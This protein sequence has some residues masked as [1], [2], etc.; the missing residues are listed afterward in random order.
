[1]NIEGWN[2]YVSCFRENFEGCTFKS[3]LISKCGG[4]EDIAIAIY[5]HSRENALK[6]MDSPVPALDNKVPSREISNGGSN[7]VRQV[8]WRIPC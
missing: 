8:I 6:W 1:M 3:E 7:L 2:K 4:N 5:Y